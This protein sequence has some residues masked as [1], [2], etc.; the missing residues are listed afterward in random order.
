M[1][2]RLLTMTWDE[3]IRRGLWL[4]YN[5]NNITYCL[6][7]AGQ[8]AG[9]DDIVKSNFIYYYDHGWREKIGKDLYMW[10]PAMDAEDTWELWLSYNAGKMCFD[11]SGLI[12][13]C[14]G[15]EGYHKYSSWAFGDMQ[16]TATPAQGLAG[17]ALFKPGHVALD[18][19]Y[20]YCIEAGEY[21]HSIEFN[22]I[23]ERDFT[24]SHAIVGIN[25]E[26]ADA[27]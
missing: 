3:L 2:A 23:S 19:G 22:K 13:W 6:G 14:M 20:G 11:C 27:R 18:I 24:N 17:Y 5:R 21:N 4:Y 26:G 1:T 9:R 16:P 7:C 10:D 15:L 8:V 25:Y 12:C